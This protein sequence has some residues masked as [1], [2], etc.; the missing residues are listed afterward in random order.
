MQPA[1]LYTEYFK[2]ILHFFDNVIAMLEI[3]GMRSKKIGKG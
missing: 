1:G 3:K 2:T